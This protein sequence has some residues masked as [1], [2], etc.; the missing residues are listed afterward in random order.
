MSVLPASPKSLRP[1]A[2][3][4]RPTPS[5]GAQA[6]AAPAARRARPTARPLFFRA[7]HLSVAALAATSLLGCAHARVAQNDTMPSSKRPA[8]VGR[9]QRA[10]DDS[11]AFRH[12]VPDPGVIGRLQAPV[13]EVRTLQNGLAVWV[14]SKRDLPLVQAALVVKAGSANDPKGAE[15][16]AGLLVDVMK[17]GTRTRTAAAIADEI[18]TLGS[19]LNVGV[20]DDATTFEVGALTDNLPAALAVMADVVQHP[21]LAERDVTRARTARLAELVAVG[22]EARALA[23]QVFRRTVFGTHP[24]G[25]TSRGFT[26]QV[27]KLQRNQLAAYHQAHFRPANAAL[28]VVGDVDTESAVA[29]AERMFG[30][31]RGQGGTDAPPPPAAAHAGGVVLIDRPGATQSQ[32]AV[33]GVGV[34]RSSKD[35]YALSLGNAILG[36]MFNSRINMNLREEKGWTYGARSSF[37]F[38]RSKG[39]FSVDAG[40]RTDVTAPA[41]HEIFGEIER[42]RAEPVTA[43]E[44]QAAKNRAILSL[45]GALEDVDAIGGMVLAMVVHGLP[46]TYLRELPDKLEAVTVE[47]V[48]RVI[49]NVLDPAQ[50]DVVV[51]G[52]AAQVEEGLRGLRHGEV[53]RCDAE[54]QPVH[55]A[56]P[57]P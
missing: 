29:L 46:P 36:G 11:Q 53:Q 41:V 12:H 1:S 31:W 57:A 37:V 33:G 18:E 42:I 7:V 3:A 17:L 49:R 34:E 50:M 9:G 16:T 48:Q 38:L 20:D 44:L 28:V 23:R 10:S 6:P 47:D 52:D 54:G 43:E 27:K 21:A 22:G 8:T 26:E 5:V 55:G 30:G 51:V 56:A 15:G 14:V 25:H 39:S 40:I 35:Y 32:V 13:P 24:Y 19:N 4:P 45:P 2:R